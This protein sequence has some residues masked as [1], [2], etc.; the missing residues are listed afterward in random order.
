M[1][2]GFRELSGR[3]TVLSPGAP[4]LICRGVVDPVTAR[5][6]AL[7]RAQPEQYER[8]KREAYVRGSGN[9]A[10]GVVTFTT[11]TAC[12]AVNE[13]IQGLIGYRGP[14]GWLWNQTRRFDRFVDRRPGAHQCT[15][16][17]ICVDRMYWGRGDVDPFL[18]R[19]G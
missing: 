13:L 4:C 2:S 1:E 17:P 19:V 15:D 5:E 10:P 16:C 12:M 14:E 11:E 7:N 18:D 3:V 9:P 8:Q 6:E